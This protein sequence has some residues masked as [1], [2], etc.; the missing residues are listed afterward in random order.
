VAELVAKAMVA[1]LLMRH[2][3]SRENRVAEATLTILGEK[4]TRATVFT[5]IRKMGQMVASARVKRRNNTP[6][7]ISTLLKEDKLGR[8]LLMKVVRTLLNMKDPNGLRVMTMA[9]SNPT[10]RVGQTLS[11]KRSEMESCRQIPL[12]YRMIR[13]R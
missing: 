5:M 13:I 2:L 6:K 3:K 7:Q 12:C 10:T 8:T 11:I 9:T 4:R 1:M